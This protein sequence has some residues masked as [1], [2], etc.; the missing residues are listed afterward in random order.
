M[1]KEIKVHLQ[2]AAKREE[3]LT[4][5]EGSQEKL[6]T[7]I[8]EREQLRH[9]NEQVGVS[10]G[11]QLLHFHYVHCVYV[12]VTVLSTVFSSNSASDCL[13]CCWHCGGH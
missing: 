9:E 6:A 3:C 13:Y 2:D 4:Q 7:L 5:L 10:A 8:K 11:C 12:P 1:L